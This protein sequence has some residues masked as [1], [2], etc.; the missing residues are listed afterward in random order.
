MAWDWTPYLAGGAAARPDSM[1]GMNPEFQSALANM[2]ASAPPDIRGQ[3]QI[4]SGYRSPEVQ[5]KLYADALAKYGSP[6]AARKWVAPPGKS[7]HGH[8]NA[9]D[10]GYLSPAAREWAHQNAAQYGLAFPLSNEDWHIELASAR[11][12]APRVGGSGGGGA[13]SG[14]F[15]QMFTGGAMAPMAAPEGNVMGQIAAQFLQ[16]RQEQQK[17]QAEQQAAEQERKNA[18]FAAPVAGGGGLGSLYG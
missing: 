16:N 12:G 2:F 14:Q 11:G 7:Q 4:K 10:L 18:L 8:G 6:E 15:G 5:A 9:G 1:S 3:L 17:A 13:D